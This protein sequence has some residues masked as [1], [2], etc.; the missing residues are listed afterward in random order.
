[1]IWLFALGLLG[2]PEPVWADARPI[3]LTLTGGILSADELT[4]SPDG[5][6]G[7]IG[8]ELHSQLSRRVGYDLSFAVAS[9]KFGGPDTTLRVFSGGVTFSKR[10]RGFEGRYRVWYGTVTGRGLRVLLS[11]GPV[12]IGNPDSR[13]PFKLSVA[14]ILANVWFNREF[15]VT[16]RSVHVTAGLGVRF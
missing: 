9:G 14:H 3:T 6:Y 2:S 1:M 15:D 4:R 8:V 10:L 12:L 13:F 5:A 16:F 7:A 11:H